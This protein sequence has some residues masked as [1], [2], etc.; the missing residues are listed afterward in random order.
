MVHDGI[1]EELEEEIDRHDARANAENDVGRLRGERLGQE[2][3]H[4]AEE[5][6]A[7]HE[8]RLEHEEE[9][10]AQ[11]IVLAIVEEVGPLAGIEEVGQLS[12]EESPRGGDDEGYE[13]EIEKIDTLRKKEELES[14]KESNRKE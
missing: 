11:H 4:I 1:K 5:E 2:G 14:I 13:E 8:A 10:A 3:L 12:A 9:A 6:D 7:H